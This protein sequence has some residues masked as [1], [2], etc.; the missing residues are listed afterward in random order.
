MNKFQVISL[1]MRAICII[2][3]FIISYWAIF[4][5][6]EL[7]RAGLWWSVNMLIIVILGYMSTVFW[8]K[9]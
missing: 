4:V 3:F 5:S 7:I 9:K 2:Y 6:I 8:E 1:I